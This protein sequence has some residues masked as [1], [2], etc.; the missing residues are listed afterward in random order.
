[1]GSRGWGW[2]KQNPAPTRLVAMPRHMHKKFQMIQICHHEQA[3]ATT[4]FEEL[5]ANAILV[6]SLAICRVGAA[7]LKVPL[8]KAIKVRQHET[9]G[10]S[11]AKVTQH[12]S[13][14]GGWSCLTS[15]PNTHYDV[16]VVKQDW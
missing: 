13:A 6:V 14:N 12:A 1:M 16:E 9:R 5:G 2:G 7:V 15:K 4:G 3:R 8:Y 10:A 11:T